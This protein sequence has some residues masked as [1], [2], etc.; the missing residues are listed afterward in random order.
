MLFLATALAV[1]A[2]SSKSAIE[3]ADYFSGKTLRVDYQFFGNYQQQGVVL[4]ALSTTGVWAGR[5]H[6]LD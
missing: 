2:K 1:S 5:H 6:N 3:F 4:D